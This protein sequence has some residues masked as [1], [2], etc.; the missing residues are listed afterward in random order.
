MEAYASGRP[1]EEEA[2][3]TYFRGPTVESPTP[4]GR[5]L[6]QDSEFNLVGF[7][8]LRA[9]ILPVTLQNGSVVVILDEHCLHCDL[10][11]RFVQ[12]GDSVRRII[13]VLVTITVAAVRATMI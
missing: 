4:R 3:A 5:N 2:R 7:E 1:T 12:W 13:P 10:L 11:C 9:V 6:S 8:L